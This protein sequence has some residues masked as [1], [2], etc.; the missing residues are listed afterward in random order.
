MQ[1]GWD[2]IMQMH[3]NDGCFLPMYRIF[4]KAS[5]DCDLANFLRERAIQYRDDVEPTFERE[6]IAE[7]SVEYIQRCG[8]PFLEHS[9]QPDINKCAICDLC[10]D[11]IVV[12]DPPPLPFVS[13]QDID[14][15][16]RG[17]SVSE[18]TAFI[19]PPQHARRANAP[20]RSIIPHPAHCHSSSHPVLPRAAGTFRYHP[21]IGFL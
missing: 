11:A 14:N 17:I 6:I 1:E 9:H 12:P 21:G 2:P 16:V 15:Y 20:T 3:I 10:D 5:T 13:M 4:E 19:T 18:D 8:I 7:V